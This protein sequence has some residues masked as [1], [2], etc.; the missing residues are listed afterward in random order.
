MSQEPDVDVIVVGAGIAGTVT[1]YQLAQQ[2]SS[3]ILFDRGESAGS[4]NLS[5]G[6]LYA[7]VM[8][9]VFPDFLDEAPIERRVE[10]NQLCF[11]N[12]DSWVALDYSDRR[13][14]DDGI[15][16]SV[17]RARL[18]AWLAEQCESAGVQVVT[19]IR[20][21][22]LLRDGEQVVGVKAGDDELRS[23][24]VVAADG[25][26][27]FICRDAGL[28]PKQALN[29]LAVGV[30]AV[31]SLPQAEIESRFGLAHNTGAAYALVGDCTL[32]LGGGGFVYTNRDSLSLGVVLRLDDLVARG[33]ASS[34][35]FEHFIERPFIQRYI[36][37]GQIIEYGCHLV[38]EGGQNMVGQ[39]VHDGLVVVGDAAGLTINSGLA[40]R[41]M[42]LAAGS[43]VAAAQGIGEALE[44]NNC[45]AAGLSAYARALESS[46]VGKDMRAFSRAPGFLENPLLY[47]S[48]GELAAD[49]LH[50]AFGI[51]TVPRQH[52]VSSAFKAVRKSPM[53]WGQLLR[54]GWRGVR[55]L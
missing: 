42:D 28:R 27:S 18:D 34:R 41:G 20:V 53:S 36:H 47:G 14:V 35:V 11:L 39:I 17:L 54:L 24:V 25:V 30:K 40:V 29:H 52:L 1:A 3:V 33:V 49:V 22:E 50:Q 4:K 7:D 37:G 23:K 8:R 2:G 38:N 46:F 12:Q 43:A 45:S 5:G 13:L 48:C 9:E 15:A 55:S 44:Q 6:I 32:G 16:V 26:N 10:R 21:D 19:G 31:V 51:S